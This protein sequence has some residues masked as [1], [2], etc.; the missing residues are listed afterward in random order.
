[1]GAEFEVKNFEKE[2]IEASQSI[3]VMVDFWADWCGPCH[4]LEPILIEL[5]ADN[6]DKMRLVKINS[7]AHQEL[8]IRYN[9]R[10]VPAIRIFRH[11]EIIASYNGLMYKKEF[12]E[13]LNGVL[14]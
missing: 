2:V 8:A 14:G 4:M 10:G 13:W 3:P 1:M 12:Q 6:K 9:I 5:L 11:G 7:D